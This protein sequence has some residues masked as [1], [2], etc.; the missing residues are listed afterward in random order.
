MN[1]FIPGYHKTLTSSNS[2]ITFHTKL[3]SDTRLHFSFLREGEGGREGEGEGEKVVLDGMTEILEFI[4]RFFRVII[5]TNNY[6]LVLDMWF[7]KVYKTSMRLIGH[8]KIK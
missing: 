5:V 3:I 2:N 7:L 6:I 8:W 4:I 1:Y